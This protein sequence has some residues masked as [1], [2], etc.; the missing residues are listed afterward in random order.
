[1][2]S[3]VFD[4]KKERIDNSGRRWESFRELAVVDFHEV[5]S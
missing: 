3:E 2:V 1:M 4:A 5:L